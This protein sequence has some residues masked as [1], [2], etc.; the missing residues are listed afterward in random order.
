[1]FNK[2]V[3][4]ISLFVISLF[5]VLNTLYLLFDLL[6]RITLIYAHVLATYVFRN[7]R[8][9]N[10]TNF[11][12]WKFQF[13]QMSKFFIYFNF[14]KLFSQVGSDTRLSLTTELGYRIHRY[15]NTGRPLLFI[16]FEERVVFYNCYCRRRRRPIVK[17]S[18]L[19]VLSA[20]CHKN[21][22]PSLL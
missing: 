21:T 3:H 6:P 15:V 22:V 10:K 2:F 12:L 9:I 8:K 14:L 13:T 20:Y 7:F 1:M 19:P 18:Q 17:S 5:R 4:N 11:L 16:R